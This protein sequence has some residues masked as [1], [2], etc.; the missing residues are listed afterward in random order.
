M[1]KNRMAAAMIAAAVMMGMTGC[2]NQTAATETTKETV[3]EA[4]AKETETTAQ[5]ADAAE[6]EGKTRIVKDTWGREVEIPDE[7]DSIVCLG[8]G[9]PRIAVYLDAEDKMAGI[10]EH[11]AEGVNILRDYSPI[12]R[13]ETRKLPLVG[14]GGGRGANNGY[15]E[16]IIMAAPDVILA[17]FSQEAA[18][19]LENQTG[20]PVV[21]VRYTSKGLANE[22]FYSA[23]RV[24]AEVVEKEERCEELLTYIDQCKEDLNSHTA[25]IPEEEKPAAY[26]GAVT[27]S[28]RHGF[29]GTYSKFGP[30]DAVNAKNVADVDTE[31]GYYE[32]DLEQILTWDPDM[33]FL[34]PGNMD[35]VSDEISGNPEYFK[36]V[37]A[38]KEENV[39][40]LPSFNNC[41]MNITYALMDAYYTGMVLYPEQFEDL[42]MEDKSNEILTTFLGEDTFSQMSEGGLIYGTLNEYFK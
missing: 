32:A 2:K 6:S 4:A 28:G 3:T 42:T 13:D 5:E 21:C 41:G 14:A 36:T 26:A 22:S 12:L 19:E 9:A 11:D 23:M 20:I 29:T 16:A 34:D 1:R 33:I 35:L 38:V 39:Y 25:E 7:V 27:F 37:R 17:G 30:F 15:A 24:F 18:E 31:D 10:E 40:A 8:S